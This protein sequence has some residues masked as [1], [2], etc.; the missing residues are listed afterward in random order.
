MDYALAD[1]SALVKRYVNE[2]G[3]AAM[4]E[5]YTRLPPRRWYVLVAG[6][7][8]VMSVLVR[9]RNTGRLS[10]T[11]FTSTVKRFL[12]EIDRPAYPRKL[13]VTR[14][15]VTRAH[16][17]IARHSVNAT[18]AVVLRA[19]LDRAAALRPRGHKLIVVAC[20]LRLLAAARAEGLPVYN[21]ETDPV[22]EFDRLLGP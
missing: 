8:E 9:K 1:A 4:N 15:R 17:L 7:G 3:S 5:V 11:A 18:D 22:S 19:A 13:E 2:P 20:D 10:P 14:R 16:A 12:A 21:P 6:V